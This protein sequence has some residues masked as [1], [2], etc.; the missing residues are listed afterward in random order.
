MKKIFF[1][2]WYWPF[3]V[4]HYIIMLICYYSSDLKV[5]IRI[6]LL[7]TNKCIIW[8][9]SKIFY[10]NP[11]ILV[12]FSSRSNQ[13]PI[14]LSTSGLCHP[15]GRP[16]FLIIASNGFS[17]NPMVFAPEDVEGAKFLKNGK[18]GFLK[19]IFDFNLAKLEKLLIFLQ[20][21]FCVIFLLWR[22]SY[23][24]KFNFRPLLFFP[25]EAIKQ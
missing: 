10:L 20:Y 1:G 23:V 22:I 2:Q 17:R 19:E 12:L 24:G 21:F 3:V 25:Q 11:T 6:D 16:L 5:C 9:L 14:K 15:V 13:V 18:I 8:K 4:F 7:N